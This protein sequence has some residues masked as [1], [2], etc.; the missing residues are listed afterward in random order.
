MSSFFT[1]LWIFCSL[2]GLPVAIKIILSKIT[3]LMWHELCVKTSFVSIGWAARKHCSSEKSE[4]QEGS[5]A[6][7]KMSHMKETRTVIIYVIWWKFN[8]EINILLLTVP[9]KHPVYV[10]FVIKLFSPSKLLYGL[11]CYIFS[12]R[13]SQKTLQKS[14]W[15]STSRIRKTT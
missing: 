14:S 5:F 13:F 3:I 8:V 10:M 2:F 9:I 11:W 6:V 1:W 7:L 15:K 4:D 12:S